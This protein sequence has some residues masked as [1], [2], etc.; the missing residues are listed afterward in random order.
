M[1]TNYIEDLLS[2]IGRTSQKEAADKEDSDKKK[3]PDFL[4]KKDD[5]KQHGRN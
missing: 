1:S 3:L 5:D 4:K 2:E